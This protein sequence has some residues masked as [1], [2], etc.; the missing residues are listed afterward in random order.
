MASPV[1]KSSQA[2]PPRATSSAAS[3]DRLR[4]V[5]VAST[6]SVRPSCSSAVPRATT[7]IPKQVMTTAEIDST[8]AR[9]ESSSAPVPPMLSISRRPESVSSRSPTLGAMAPMTVPRASTPTVQP[10]SAGWCTRQ[11]RASTSA[12]R[13]EPCAGPGR[14]GNSPEPRSRLARSA[15][16]ATA[17]TPARA[18]YSSR[19][20][21]RGSD[22]ADSRVF[23]PN[24][25]SQ[26]SHSAPTSPTARI[27]Y[28]TAR[29]APAIPKQ[30]RLLAASWQHSAVSATETRP[31]PT[32]VA[33]SA[34]DPATG[35]PPAM[36]ATATRAPTPNER[37]TPSTRAAASNASRPIAVPA[38]SSA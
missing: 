4:E 12:S 29:A 35:S 13:G 19:T 22:H 1:A 32:Q 3:R 33:P 37:A 34:S 7:A 18:T 10:S 2:T 30:V 27:R 5:A 16:A 23:Q 28:R 14:A 15:C 24:G 9:S 20:H 6:C 38:S 17:R 21:Q 26:L 11:V 36:A 31:I 25:V 8:A